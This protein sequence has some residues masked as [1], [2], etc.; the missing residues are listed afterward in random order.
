MTNESKTGKEWCI[1]RYL[2][3]RAER[4]ELEKQSGDADAEIK[5][6]AVGTMLAAFTKLLPKIGINYCDIVK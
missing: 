4:D 2:D 5:L 1:A 3:L 6:K